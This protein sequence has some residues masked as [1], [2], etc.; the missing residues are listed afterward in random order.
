MYIFF[1]CSFNFKSLRSHYKLTPKAVAVSETD[2]DRKLEKWDGH[3]VANTYFPLSLL[4]PFPRH[5]A[6]GMVKQGNSSS[7]C[8]FNSS[9]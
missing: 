3:N 6:G 9:A 1:S 7:G 4:G 8:L 5:R 2:A